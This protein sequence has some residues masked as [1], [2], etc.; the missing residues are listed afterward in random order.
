MFVP[1]FLQFQGYETRDFQTSTRDQTVYVDLVARV[2]KPYCCYRC[3]SDLVGERGHHR[4]CLRDLPLRG[5]QTIVRLWRRKGFC[6]TCKKV[7]SEAIAFLSKESP[8]FTQD[9]AWWLGTMC[10]FSPVSR[11]AELV[12][13]GNMTVRR[14]DLKRMQRMLKHY[15]IPDVTHI[16]VDEVYARKKSRY[17]DEDRDQRFFTVITDLNTRRVIWVAESR[18]KAALDQFFK[19]L[20][21]QACERIQVVAVD[22][23]DAYAASVKEH[24]KKAKVVWDKFHIIKNFEEAVNEVRKALHQ[25]LPNK[26][27]LLKLT[28]GKYRFA[29]LKKASR[30]EAEEARHIEAVVR[31]N[32]DFAA[33]EIIKERM[34]TFFDCTD[35]RSAWEVLWE[36]GRWIQQKVA[37]D[38][39]AG[40]PA[41]FVHLETWWEN[42]ASGWATLKNYFEFPVTSSLAE[43]VNNV[44]KSLKRK[45]FGFRNM[46]YFRLKIMQVCGYLNSRYIKFAEMLGT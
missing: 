37:A 32:K 40:I 13:E 8:H 11:V 46:D 42:L 15:K 6:P 33:L 1:R 9:Y 36:L 30:R 4:L 10:E 43:G 18:K 22:Q 14:I 23:H 45:A 24:C 26:S 21:K 29:F 25:R 27:P 28:R 17:K 20:G 5:F 31:E 7:R 3:G 2:D 38:R 39:L 19:L 34:L 16:A 41:A 35:A 44:I 12:S